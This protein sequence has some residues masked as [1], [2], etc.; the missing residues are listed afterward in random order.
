MSDIEEVTEGLMD[1]FRQLR[2]G[3]MEPKD[4]MEINNT[5]GKI[6]SAYKTRI[7]YH[8]L[9]DERPTIEGLS[10]TA[11][12]TMIADGNVIRGGRAVS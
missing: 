8:A 12:P 7:A 3:T 2:D 11:K 6:I 1:V 9:R 5:A 4:A 10:T